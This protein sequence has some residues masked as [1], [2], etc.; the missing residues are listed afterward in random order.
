MALPTWTE[1]HFRPL[2]TL[3]DLGREG[4]SGSSPAGLGLLA[5]PRLGRLGEKERAGQIVMGLWVPPPAAGAVP[6]P[7][8]GWVP[9]A[10][11]AVWGWLS[12]Q[13]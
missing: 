1:F 13:V 7:L 11:G 2:F 6:S 8:E 10:R 12:A 4:S 9:Q 3:K 5:I